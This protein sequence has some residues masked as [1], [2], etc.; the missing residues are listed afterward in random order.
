MITYRHH[1]VSLV[2]V[3]LALAV[4]VVLG[5]GP[6]ADARTGDD[7]TADEA[8]ASTDT[9]R[10]ER[11]A[12]ADT[13]ATASAAALLDGGLEGRSVALLSAGGPDDEV[14]AA[15]TAHVEEAGGEVT[16]RYELLD[17]LVGG[18][19]TSLVD[20]LGTRLAD[21]VDDGAIDP[22]APAYDR[23]GQLLGLAVATSAP[24][25]TPAGGNAR[26]VRQGLAGADLLAGS[27][28]EADRAPLVLLVLGDDTDP[29]VLSGLV[30]G[31]ATVAGGTVLAAGSS[32]AQDG[33]L[34]AIR[35]DG[36]P[37]GVVSVDGVETPAGQVTAALA[38]LV[39]TNGA[40]GDY[41][42]AGAD[43]AVPLD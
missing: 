29:D 41:G 1:V 12:Y 17:R 22:D 32:S 27:D 31:L 15:L 3:F 5:G 4:G 25:G 18:S 19:S 14:L 2:A 26:T 20:T 40:G 11:G 30:S 42:P 33:T 35:E 13:F 6:L 21:E 24:D 39:A 16:A 28:P 43:G 8:S 9:T 23:L 7:P 38:L 34:A 36:T 37:G 10:D